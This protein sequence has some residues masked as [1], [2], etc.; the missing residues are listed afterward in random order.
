MKETCVKACVYEQLMIFSSEEGFISSKVCLPVDKVLA[1]AFLHLLSKGDNGKQI[2][3]LSSIQKVHSPSSAA[4]S[5]SVLF[6]GE[7]WKMD[8]TEN[9]K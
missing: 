1:L 2:Y 9:E 7:W 8:R 6:T 5:S 4:A 3:Q